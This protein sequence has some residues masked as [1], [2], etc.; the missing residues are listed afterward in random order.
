MNPA[1]SLALILAT[2]AV[3]ADEDHGKA[4][5]AF[6]EASFGKE[7]AEKPHFVMFFAPW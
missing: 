2:A 3:F 7:V 4:S 5:K 6:N 1:F